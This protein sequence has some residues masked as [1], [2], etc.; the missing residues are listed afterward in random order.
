MKTF[1][2]VAIFLAVAFLFVSDSARVIKAAM[3]VAGWL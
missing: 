2:A 3:A 1:F